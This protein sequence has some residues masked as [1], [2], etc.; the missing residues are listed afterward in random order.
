MTAKTAERL[1]GVVNAFRGRRVLVI[2]DLVAD[3]FVYGRVER[4]SR[5]APVLIL[6]YDSTDLRL[7]GGANAIHNIC[8]LGGRPIPFGVLGRD[9]VGRCIR[10]QLRKKGI[11]TSR[12]VNDPDYATPVKT[13]ILA[14]RAHSTKQ[15]IVRM[16]KVVALRRPSAS[17]RAVLEALRA[18]KGPVDGVLVSDYGCGLLTPEIVK[19]AVAYARRRRVPVT[20]DS[21]FDLLRYKGMTAVTP[22]EPEVEAALGITIGHDKARLEAAG[23]TLLERLGCAAVLVTRGSHGM[24]LFERGRPP[25]HIPIH[26]T[27]EVADVTGAGDT[28][29]ATFTLA[30]AAGATP[31][32]ASRLANYAGSVVVMKH[33]TATVSSAELLASVR[34]GEGK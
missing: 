22:N 20:V 15:Q 3:E 6:R 7:G 5:E 9:D 16:D 26:G 17:R 28:V 18:Y 11:G 33:A 14:G 21:R 25:L 24:T 32:E 34:E 12:V 27:D 19:A 8:S 13:R 2:A 1:T 23:R 31:A 29:I 4:I 10:G 30:L